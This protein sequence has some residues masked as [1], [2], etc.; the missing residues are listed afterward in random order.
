MGIT[1][2]PDVC[3]LKDK[4]CECTTEMIVWWCAVTFQLA[5]QQ[6]DAQLRKHRTTAFLSISQTFD[7]SQCLRLSL[8]AL[9]SCLRHLSISP[10]L[11]SF[12]HPSFQLFL[13]FLL[14]SE[15]LS[16]VK[17]TSLLLEP[18]TWLTQQK[19]GPSPNLFTY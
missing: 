18:K 14:L 9:R 12:P 4:A 17:V 10:F 11:L 2:S 13:F 16:L 7:N 6:C 5:V 19:M 8:V 1:A 3:H 15:I